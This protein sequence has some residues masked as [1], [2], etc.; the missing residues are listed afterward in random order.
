MKNILQKFKVDYRFILMIALVL[1]LFFISSVGLKILFKHTLFELGNYSLYSSVFSTKFGI[2]A[3]IFSLSIL[4]LYRKISW[5][6]FQSKDFRYFTFFIVLV[7]TWKYGFYEYNYYLDSFH[8]FDRILLIAVAIA[9][10]FN[11]LFLPLFILLAITIAAQ[12]N[13]PLGLYSFTDEKPL[14]DTLILVSIFMFAKVMYKDLKTKHLIMLILSMHAANYFYPGFAKIYISPNG[15]EWTLFHDLHYFIINTYHRGWFNFLTEE[16]VFSF[17]EFIKNFNLV[18]NIGTMILQLGAI[19][20]LFNKRLAIW[21]LIGFELL[22]IGVY[23]ATGIFF[24]KW[25]LLNLAIIWLVKRLDNECSEYLFD[26]KSTRYLSF[27]IILLSPLYF[28][29]VWLAWFNTKLNNNYYFTIETNGGDK[30]NMAYNDFSPYQKFFAFERYHQINKDEKFLNINSSVPINKDIYKNLNI[31][32]NTWYL[33]KYLDGLK[34]EDVL[35]VIEEKGES[36]YDEEYS[37]KFDDFI[38]IYF[39]NLNNYIEK[40]G[41]RNNHIFLPFSHIHADARNRFDFNKP[42]KK[43]TL[44]YEVKF[45]DDE[46]IYTLKSK[47]IKEY[48][49]K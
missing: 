34:K 11:P 8:L 44:R 23:L 45:F 9:V 6:Q 7:L 15:Y 16:Q 20:I 46:G 13:F 35:N 36:V 42:I 12:L 33:K 41:N 5:E 3:I 19:F 27:I 21:L 25:I 26:I 39:K 40:N 48:D 10:Y 31:E 4:S 43:V 37:K 1:C 30:Y 17:A 28:K 49:I 18:S 22:H 14:W 47:N 24:W 32:S 38:L 29:P 2:A